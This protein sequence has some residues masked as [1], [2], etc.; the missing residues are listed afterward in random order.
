[1][2]I[3]AARLLVAKKVR[4]FLSGWRH[5]IP[6]VETHR[7]TLQQHRFRFSH[8]NWEGVVLLPLELNTPVYTFRKQP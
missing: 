3:G 4:N 6:R 5:P 1:M 2:S 7:N 8:Q